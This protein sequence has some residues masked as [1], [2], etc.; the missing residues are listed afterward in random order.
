MS[1]IGKVCQLKHLAQDHYTNEQPSRDTYPLTEDEH[2]DVK[3][4]MQVYAQTPADLRAA[5]RF[6]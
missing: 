5:E 3:T 2:I 4:W 6:S 1:F